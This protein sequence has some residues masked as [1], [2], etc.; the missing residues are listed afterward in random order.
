M[1][2]CKRDY[3]CVIGSLNYDIIM[4]QKRMPFLGET[5]TADSITYSGGG[6]GANQAVQCAK[7]GID[8]I[9]VGKVGRDSF[10]DTLVEK[11]RDYGVDCSCIGRSSSPTG[12]GVVHALEDG[13]VYASIITG[14]NFDITAREIDGLDELVR[15]SRIIILQLE[16]P[17]NV[18]EHIIRKA[19]QYHVYTILN[20][21]PAKELDREVLKLV[22]CLIVNET[23]A[24][25]YAGV[26]I[27]D[28]EMV[29]AHA[30]RL[31]QLTEGTVIVTLGSKGS[32]LLGKEETVSI[33]PVKVEHVTE[34]TGAG[35]SYIGAF[36]YGKYKGMTDRRAC[37]FA[38]RAASITVTKIGAQ[39]AMP[40]LNEIDESLVPG[41]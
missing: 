39:E 40:C 22:D 33:E 14:A 23:E 10:G 31:S 35:D 9:M 4:K 19:K 29:R 18:V 20:A 26:D 25:F 34:S 2:D 12:V 21:A 13:T 7:L 28:G 41:V 37:C 17:T 1:R 3:I 38:A 32:M 36:A 11:L 16:I 24:S 15:N 27:T 8:T 30:D 6:K 5:Y